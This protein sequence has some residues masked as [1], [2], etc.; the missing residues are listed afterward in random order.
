[1]LYSAADVFVAPSIMEPFGKT[2]GEAMACET[3]V[4]CFDATGPKDIVDHKE[5]GYKAKAF[6]PEE[7]GEGIKWVAQN[8]KGNHLGKA[9]REKVVREFSSEVVA[10]KY[11]HLYD[12][13]L[14]ERT[15]P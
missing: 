1:I 11:I 5:N 14:N 10:Q 4:V 15:N 8:N 6:N 2:L 12:S 3:P 9:G 13:V 7:L